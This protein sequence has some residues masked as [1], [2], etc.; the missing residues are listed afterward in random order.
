MRTVKKPSE[1]L[2]TLKPLK[3]ERPKKV[4]SPP[5]QGQGAVTPSV[6][7]LGVRSPRNRVPSTLH[8]PL[9]R[10]QLLGIRKKQK[11]VPS[12]LTACRQLSA[13]VLPC[14]KVCP[15]HYGAQGG[16]GVGGR[17]LRQKHHMPRRAGQPSGAIVRTCFKTPV[18]TRFDPGATLVVPPGT[19]MASLWRRCGNSGA[20]C[21][22]P[23]R[24]PGGPRRDP[25]STPVEPRL[26][27]GGNP[28]GPRSVVISGAEGGS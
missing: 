23:G 17:P 25:G 14:D 24:I 13:A 15:R 22:D 1:P 19:G 21:P 9:W 16:A 18:A 8:V 6:L 4:P 28:V 2:K 3:A 20:A 12:T 7:L 5:A 10:C 26:N 11:A 27:P